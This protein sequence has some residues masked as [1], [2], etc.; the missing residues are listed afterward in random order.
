MSPSEEAI[1]RVECG[2]LRLRV[3]PLLTFI[4]RSP[5]RSWSNLAPAQANEVPRQLRGLRWTIQ[6]VQAWYQR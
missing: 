3:E 1:V 4:S 2:G 5:D 6:H